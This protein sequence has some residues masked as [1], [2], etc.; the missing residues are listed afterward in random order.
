MI[1]IGP[2]GEVKRSPKPARRLTIR[3][4]D[5]LRRL[6]QQMPW[7]TDA[8]SIQG[9][10][11]R[12][13]YT[14]TSWFGLL[15]GLAA[16]FVSVFALRL[17]AT[18]GQ[19]G[20]LTA[21][22]ALVNVVWLIPA[23][24]LIERQRRRL[25]L[26]LIT[27]VLQRLGYLV[28]A[29][30]PFVVVT[31]RVEA[32]IA[33]NTL[34][35][36][37]AAVINTAITSLIPDLTPPEH[38]GQVVS[39]RWL[40][41]S[42]MATVAALGAG[43]LLDQM[44]VPLN[45]QVLLGGGALLSLF[46]LRFL[47]RI[48]VPDEVTARRVD[49]PHERYSWSRLRQS[50]TNVLSHRAFVRFALASFVFYWG[51]Y[52]PAALWSVL[53]VRD[54]DATDTWIGIIAVVVNAATIAGYFTWGKVSAK[55]GERRVLIVTGIGVAAYALS[56]ALVP[57]IAWMIPT[58][59]LGG[60]TWSGCNLALFTVM[61]GVCPDDHRPSYLAF[62]TALM[63]VAAFAAPLLGAALSDWVGIRPAFVVSSG[64]RLLG[65]LLFLRLVR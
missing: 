13:L 48:Q 51:L 6:G 43:R 41:L 63:N 23:A 20:W 2:R 38:R 3:G 32:L 31:G 15:N 61:L 39:A 53:R 19:V 9:R 22:T 65:A 42:A 62:Y 24:R 45:Y 4:R 25:P 7:H 52:L 8:G 50:L 40:I 17:G 44:P 54:L 29:L 58:S 36:L 28:M 30:M 10:N 35:T 1:R 34:I 12:N 55:W 18:T 60:L 11:V 5:S 33:I 14:E 46:S 47:R 26:I 27:G 59:I 37:P 49:Q 16:T 64:L 56:T 21:L 57:T